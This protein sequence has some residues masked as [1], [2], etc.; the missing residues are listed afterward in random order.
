MLGHIREIT[1]IYDL[2]ALCCSYI[3]K[4]YD[5]E[6]IEFSALNFE[7]GKYDEVYDAIELY[8]EQ[9]DE[10]GHAVAINELKKFIFD[11]LHPGISVENVWR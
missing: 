7:D 9:C 4:E 11:F 8:C 6:P 10:E 5:K 2:L 3:F 1:K